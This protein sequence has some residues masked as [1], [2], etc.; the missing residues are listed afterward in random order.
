MATIEEIEKM[1]RYM[2]LDSRGH[3]KLTD[4]IDGKQYRADS[5]MKCPWPAMIRKYGYISGEVYIHHLRCKGKCKYAIT[6]QFHGG[7]RCG[8]PEEKK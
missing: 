5:M 3:E 7:V 1:K 6:F 2:E 8:Y 4:S